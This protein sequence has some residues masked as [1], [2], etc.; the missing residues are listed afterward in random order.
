MIILPCKGV[1]SRAWQDLLNNSLEIE[2]FLVTHFDPELV[3]QSWQS[4]AYDTEVEEFKQ[5]RF[6]NDEIEDIYMA[7]PPFLTP[8]EAWVLD[9]E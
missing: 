4:K 7:M 6:C 2:K 3:P 1:H 9:D 8:E 5:T